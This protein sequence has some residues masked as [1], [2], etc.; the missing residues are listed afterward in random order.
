[1]T[2]GYRFESGDGSC[3]YLG[4]L[5][6]TAAP[7]RHL[8]PLTPNFG[9]SRSQQPSSLFKNPWAT[10]LICPHPFCTEPEGSRLS[11]PPQ[12]YGVGPL[13][14]VTALYART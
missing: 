4:E 10:A 6:S 1:M 11:S 12:K 3:R 13:G 8:M 14:T 7:G 9:A 2:F 5:L